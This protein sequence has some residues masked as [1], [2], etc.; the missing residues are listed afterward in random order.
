MGHKYKVMHL[1][2]QLTVTC[3]AVDQL[4]V[5]DRK[6]YAISVM[7]YFED[8]ISLKIE[9]PP[10]IKKY[11][12]K[13]SYAPRDVI[14]FWR[15][16]KEHEIDVIHTHHTYTSAV[17]RL[18]G[19]L[20]GVKTLHE[21]GGGHRSYS[22]QSQMLNTLTLWMGDAIVCVSNF[23]YDSFNPVEKLTVARRKVRIIPFGINL[24]HIKKRS[25]DRRSFDSDYGFKGGEF[26]ISHTARLVPVKD[27]PFLLRLA[28]DMMK[29]DD[30][31][32]L[33]IAG[34]GEERPMLE[35]LAKDLGIERRVIFTG[36]VTREE[37][38]R[39]LYF[40]D[41]FM[42]TSDSEGMSASLVEALG[43]GVP[44]VLSD[45]PSFRE[46]LGTS[47]AGI[48]IDKKAGVADGAKKA[49]D[50]INAAEFPEMKKRAKRLAYETFDI[51]VCIRAFEAIY[52]SLLGVKAPDTRQKPEMFLVGK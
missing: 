43:F 34:D 17:A 5:H 11:A 35:R 39:I 30:R 19:L 23:V 26:V 9:L 21:D 46:A 52:D 38:Y 16:V 18:I 51:K 48:L 40:S 47:N 49:L 29:A 42:M 27:E 28:A 2:N 24:D 36:L 12:F 50:M 13:G 22:L 6:K 45:I 25:Y 37:V 10:D 31:I 14:R 15:F 33:I 4:L 8:E 20:T 32:R 1:V 41:L 44:A 3:S 7:S